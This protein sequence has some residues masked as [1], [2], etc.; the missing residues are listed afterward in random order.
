VCHG[1][2]VPRAHAGLITAPSRE[3]R[4]DPNRYGWDPWPMPEQPQDFVDGL[5][6]VVVNGDAEQQTGIG[7]HVYA[8]NRSMTDRVFAC[9]DGELLIVPQHG[10]LRLTTELGILD[11]AVGEIALVPRSLKFAVELPAGP[12]RGFVCENYGAHFRL[13]ELGPIGANGLANARDFLA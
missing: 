10:A 6:T 5:L 2:L 13:P 11:V 1:E 12:V 7:I 8:A 4:A 3:T 9:I